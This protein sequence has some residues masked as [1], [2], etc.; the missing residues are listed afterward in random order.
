MITTLHPPAAR[1]A[2]LPPSFFKTLQIKLNR[3]Q[4]AGVDVI[5]MDMGSPDLPPP[6][7]ILEA[8]DRS[9]ARPDHHGYMPFGGNPAYRNAWADFYGQRFGVELDSD[10]EINGLLGSKEGIFKLPLAYVNPGD[11]VLVPDPGYATYSA[12]AVFAGAE[13]V[14]MPLTAENHYLPDFEALAPEVVARARLMWLN[15]PNNPTGAVATVEFFARAV[16]FAR[17]H[18]ILL[19]HD[20][21]YTEITYDSYSAPSVLQVPGAKEV[22]VE[23]QSLSKTANMAGWR[24]GVIC[25]NADV[26]RALGALQS[27]I[28]SGSFRPILDAAIVALTGDRTWQVARNEIYRERRDLVVAGARAAGLAAEVPAA[29]IYVWARLPAGTDDV[30]YADGLLD[31]AGVTV[32]PGSFFGPSGH[33][34]VRLSFCTPTE[35]IREAMTRWQEWAARR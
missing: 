32:T 15:Y 26:I 18:G 17:K 5:R 20:A 10:S 31:G 16:A 33:G 25:G 9:A 23:F 19:A 7:H 1:M 11:V 30:A 13:V 21:P 6:A 28:D 14:Y 29:S 22:A 27:N 3:L 4:A 12:G 34:Y 24:S 35:R 2:A 8:L